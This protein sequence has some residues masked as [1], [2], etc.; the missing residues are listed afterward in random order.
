MDF[1]DKLEHTKHNLTGCS[2]VKIAL[3]LVWQERLRQIN[4]WGHQTHDDPRWITILAE[5]F[6]E[7]AAEV[8][9][10]LEEGMDTDEYMLKLMDELIQVAAVAVAHVEH[11]MERYDV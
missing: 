3:D 4:K 2:K 6:G 11:L 10:H 5:E 7:A 8:C 1:K 9:S